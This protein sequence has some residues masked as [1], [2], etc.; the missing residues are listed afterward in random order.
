M[1]LAIGA[2]VEGVPTTFHTPLAGQAC[3]VRALVPIAVVI[4]I[5]LSAFS[6]AVD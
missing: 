1:P 4:S 6:L 5:L 3:P 2:V